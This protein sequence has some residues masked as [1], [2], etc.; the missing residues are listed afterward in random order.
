MRIN[1]AKDFNGLAHDGGAMFS[2]VRWLMPSSWAMRL[3]G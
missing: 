1:P 3:L 2:T